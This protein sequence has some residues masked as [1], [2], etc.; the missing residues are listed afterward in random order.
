M[1]EMNLLVQAIA[2]TLL[3]LG[4]VVVLWVVR[5]T[6]SSKPLLLPAVAA[7][8]KHPAYQPERKAA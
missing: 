4:S 1:S 3:L 5:A 2:A 6:D 8:K 7:A